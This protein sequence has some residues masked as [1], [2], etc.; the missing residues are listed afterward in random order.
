MKLGRVQNEAMRV[1]LGTTKDTPT[2]TMRYLL[3]LPS[4]ETR[5][6]VDQVKTYLNAICR[7]PRIHSTMLSKKKRGVDWQVMDGS[8]RTINPACV[9]SCRVQ[10][11]KALGK[12][13]SCVQALEQETAV[14]EP[15]H[16]LPW[17]A[18]WNSQCRST[19]ACHCRSQ[20]Q[21]TWY[22]DQHGRLSHK[23]PVWLGVHG[24]AGWKDCAQRQ[25]S[26]QSQD[27]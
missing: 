25:W 27:L 5:H 23:G 12:T 4:I 6:K 15:R 16:A 21:A 11:S 10:A 8:S 13:S 18:S 19:K 14:R 2:E 1:I 17:M 7:I 22:R 20:Q 9:Q 26:P 24:L 3:D